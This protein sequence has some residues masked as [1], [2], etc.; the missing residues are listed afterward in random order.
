MIEWSTRVISDWKMSDMKSDLKGKYLS[1]LL[2]S[3]HNP[4]YPA[5][6]PWEL[7]ITTSVCFPLVLL[8]QL[9]YHVRFYYCFLFFST[10][11][12][13]TIHPCCDNIQW[14][15][16]H[17]LNTHTHTHNLT[18]TIKTFCMSCGE[19]ERMCQNLENARHVKQHPKKNP[20]IIRKNDIDLSYIQWLI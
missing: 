18:S 1:T 3:R 5:H 6:V 9:A 17:T 16:L 2:F 7:F 10:L 14:T 8:F 4:D 15:Y 12:I 19:R 11:N 13:I 20:D